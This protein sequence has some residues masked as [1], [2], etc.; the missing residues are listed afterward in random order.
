MLSVTRKTDY[1][2]VAMTYLASREG[3]RVSAREIA[4]Q[5]SLPVPALMNILSQLVHTGLIQST[6]GPNG[7]YTLAMSPEKI[8]LAA[9]IEA[10][11]GPVRL[12]LCCPPAA[13]ED[14]DGR[15]CELQR[16]C[17]IRE[18]ILKVHEALRGF[19]GLITLDQLVSN[20]ISSQVHEM[21][22][23]ARCHPSAPVQLEYGNLWGAASP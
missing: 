22:R 10:V 9:L 16:S 6:R 21:G 17:R 18:P 5:L 23:G 13:A 11:E 20:E 3:V 4:E 2:L 1:A 14:V 12:T 7:G 8:S 15:E 19:L